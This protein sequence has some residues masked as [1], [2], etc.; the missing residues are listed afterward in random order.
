MATGTRLI[1]CRTRV[2]T[3]DQEALARRRSVEINPLNSER[4][5]VVRRAPLRSGGPRR[6]AVVIDRKWPS[7]GARLTVQFLDGPTDALRK[8]ILSHMNAWS[9]TA[10]VQFV[11]TRGTGQVRIARLDSP[12]DMAGYWSYI[13]TE[14]LA[15]DAP[16]PTM[17]LEGFTMRTSDAEF[18]RVVRHETG[19]TLGFEHEHMRADLIGR[20]DRRKAYVYFERTEGWD[21]DETRE[22]V[23]TPLSKRSIMGTAESD[24]HS[25]MCYQIP[26]EITKNGKAIP[27]GSDITA[28]DY[29]FAGRIYPKRGTRTRVPAPAVTA[30][31]QTED[32]DAA[33]LIPAQAGGAAPSSRFGAVL[34]LSQAD[35]DSETFHLTVMERFKEDARSDERPVYVRLFASYAGARVTAPMKVRRDDDDAKTRFPNIIEMHERI[36]T[37]T[38]G[39]KA[40]LPTAA[41]LTRFGTDLFETLFQGEVRR[42]YDEARARQ[43]GRK[44]NFVFTSM[45][46]WIAE[47]PWEF[48]YDPS[49]RSFLAVED[50]YFLRNVLTPIPTEII[51]PQ[52]GPLRILI[53]YAQPRGYDPLSVEQEV[54]TIRDG[55]K[56]LT[57]DGIVEVDELPHANPDNLHMA[58]AT[59]G[60]G[61]VHFVGH[62][63]F[64]QREV[65]EDD[66]PRA[67]GALVLEDEGGR[68]FLLWGQHAREMFCGRGIR[69]V[70]LNACETGQGSRADFNLGLAQT[71]VVRG[72]PA[73]VANQYSVLDSSAAQ[74]ARAF[75]WALAH[76]LSIGHAAREA[77]VAVGR[78]PS[79]ERI[80][81]AVPV[82]YTRSP[83]LRLAAPRS[84]GVLPAFAAVH[85]KSRRSRRA[86]R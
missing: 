80:D 56:P 5:R 61:V 9:K 41:D 26:A 45:V 76:G 2:L 63:T 1:V 13:G 50:V 8:R 53:A 66:P 37:Y 10:N 73:L 14:I 60:F 58:L 39:G 75:Y 33:P 55:L 22:Q 62:G 35:D 29:A 40:E 82:V 25:V 64:R 3:P 65:A 48:A 23:L 16:E 69:L 4:A 11:E 7:A 57:E 83:G 34:P 72:L 51:A 24:P 15:I 46:S 38:N 49:R 70:F 31:E 52:T 36:R 30:A 44:L 6:L 42:L 17:N 27:G 32:L 21:E 78:S 79:S 18:H 47:K 67:D 77:R 81:W 28:T 43:V 59:G 19:H 74:F 12:E 86:R 20:I 84:H 85:V 68:E 54:A 71:L